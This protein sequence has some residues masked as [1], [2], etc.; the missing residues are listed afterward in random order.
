[1]TDLH[2]TGLLLRFALRRDRVLVSAW[3]LVLVATVAASAAA[4]GP[5]Y[6]TEADRVAAAEALN[7]SPAVVALY[8][9]ILDTSSPSTDTEAPLTL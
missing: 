4:T 1:M 8:G 7:A 3:V 2:G 9:P 5:L 6:D